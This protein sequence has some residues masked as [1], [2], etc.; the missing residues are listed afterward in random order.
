MIGVA[1]PRK[2][3]VRQT[4]EKAVE[5]ATKGSR[6]VAAVESCLLFFLGLCA[7]LLSCLSL[8]VLLT[9]CCVLLF[10]CG[11]CGS[12]LCLL[13]GGIGVIGGVASHLL[14]GMYVDLLWPMAPFLMFWES[15]S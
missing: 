5:L 12:V 1:S 10:V 11:L 8:W 4:E 15:M 7:V 9:P 2:R 6:V 13:S 14:S 3:H